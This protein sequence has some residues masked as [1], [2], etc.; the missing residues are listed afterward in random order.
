[1]ISSYPTPFFIGSLLHSTADPHLLPFPSVLYMLSYITCLLEPADYI[2]FSCKYYFSF[3]SSQLY[4]RF[5]LM[6]KAYL[7]DL[8]FFY[9][10]KEMVC[11]CE[12]WNCQICVCSGCI[13]CAWVVFEYVCAMTMKKESVYVR[14]LW[15]FFT[16]DVCVCVCV[17]V[18]WCVIK[19]KSWFAYILSCRWEKKK[20]N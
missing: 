1:M 6:N 3:L 13:H 11:I 7:V 10:R 12:K 19:K 4:K 17:C 2:P 16:L 15:L 14:E 8:T 5:V 20:C 18:M 9:I